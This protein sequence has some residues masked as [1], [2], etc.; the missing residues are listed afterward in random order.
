MRPMNSTGALPRSS[1][2]PDHVVI[3]TGSSRGIGREIARELL[4]GGSLVVLNGRDPERLEQTRVALL[5]PGAS[6]D[7]PRDTPN[8]HETLGADPSPSGDAPKRLIA[9]VADVSTEEGARHLVESAINAF[10][11]VDGLV[12]NV[13][14]SMRGALGD[15]RVEA[16]DNLYRTNTLGVILPTIAALPALKA[17]GG[18]VLFVSTVG[19]LWGFP[20]VSLYS[21]TKAAVTSFARSL[22]AEYRSLGVSST[23]VFLGFVENDPD[24]ETLA[25]DGSRHRYS[26]KAQ[27][28]QKQAAGTI[29]RALA[30]RRR[31]VITTVPGKALA[32]ATRLAPGLV[33]RIL[34]RSGNRIHA[35]NRE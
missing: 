21:A 28:T 32:L 20:H 24:K 30:G 35:V 22:D 3:V 29:V 6:A 8:P 27:L 33:A 18:R 12:N 16:I 13:G 14:I 7:P 34:A 4:A 15:L 26:R 9:V 25:P 19:A 1:R 23:V 17:S 11:R 10:G 2:P 5:N 31:E